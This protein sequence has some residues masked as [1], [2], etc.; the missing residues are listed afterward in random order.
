MQWNQFT[1]SAAS[2]L[3]YR[4]VPECLQAALTCLL[5]LLQRWVPARPKERE[6]KTW[7]EGGDVLPGGLGHDQTAQ[8]KFQK[9]PVRHLAPS[10]VLALNGPGAWSHF[11]RAFLHIL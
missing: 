6:G 5:L 1:Y 3:R 10:L 8:N 4:D 11:L 7:A 9:D 2:H